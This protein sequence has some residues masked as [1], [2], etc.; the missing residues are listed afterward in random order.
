MNFAP[1]IKVMYLSGNP[2]FGIV[3]ME[4]TNV[5][6]LSLH[7][8]SMRFNDI[9]LVSDAAL[10]IIGNCRVLQMDENTIKTFPIIKLIA[11][12]AVRVEL[13]KNLIPD[14]PCTALDTIE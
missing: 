9:D 2:L 5:P 8:V 10:R 12:S 14:V 13:H 3:F 11:S 4:S 6:L 7:N 1:N